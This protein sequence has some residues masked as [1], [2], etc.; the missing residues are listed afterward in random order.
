MF[1]DNNNPF[2]GFASVRRAMKRGGQGP[3]LS[4][5]ALGLVVVGVG[6]LYAPILI[7]LGIALVLVG[8]WPMAARHRAANDAAQLEAHG[9]REDAIVALAQ[10][11]A[12]MGSSQSIPARNSLVGLIN[13]DPSAAENARQTCLANAATAPP[14]DTWLD[15]ANE[16]L[17]AQQKPL[18]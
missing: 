1:Q 4:L 15:A 18:N 7:L 17:T 13:S 3:T 14:S 8:G 5:V 10:Q 11:I 12:A 9:A 6:I 2:W 16:I